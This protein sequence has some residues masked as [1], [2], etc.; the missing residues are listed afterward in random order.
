MALDY[1]G[2]RLVPEQAEG[3]SFWE[4]AYRYRFALG[5]ARGRTV[6]DIASGEGYGTA[7]LAAVAY[8]AIGVD[9]SAEAVEHAKTRYKID[10]RGGQA[11]LIPVTDGSAEL[12]VSFETIEHLRSPAVFIRECHR[13]L[14]PG[15]QLIISTPNR[16]VYSS[17]GHHNEFHVTE[18][19]GSRNSRTSYVRTSPL[20]G[21]TVNAP[22]PVRGGGSEM[23]SMMD[24]PGHRTFL[25]GGCGG[26]CVRCSA[27]MSFKHQRTLFER[28]R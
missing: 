27:V 21:G 2:E 23:R 16:E 10:A 26:L 14:A 8:S 5:F 6:L 9:I 19:S 17:G 28:T 18:M 12:V 15:G 13:V 7:A 3:Y 11:E 22:Q 4:H 24:P 25:G 1:T 20:R